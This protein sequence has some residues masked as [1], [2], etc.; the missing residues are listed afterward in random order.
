MFRHE[1][2]EEEE[3]YAETDSQLAEEN[4]SL[5]LALMGVGGALVLISL[6]ILDLADNND[7]LVGLFLFIVVAVIGFCLIGGGAW[8]HNEVRA[9]YLG[10]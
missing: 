5:G 7:S 8:H 9:R 6:L 3:D 4:D 2:E 10:A 1:S